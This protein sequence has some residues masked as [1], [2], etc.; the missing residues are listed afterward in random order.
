MRDRYIVQLH[1]GKIAWFEN[2]INYDLSITSDLVEEFER[3][4]PTYV[5]LLMKEIT[6]LRDRL[7]TLEQKLNVNVSNKD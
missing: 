6:K 4:S 2:F 3:F 1:P 5:I 7:K